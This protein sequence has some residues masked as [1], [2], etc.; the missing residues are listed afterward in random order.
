MQ[1]ILIGLVC[2]IAGCTSLSNS[3]PDIWWETAPMTGPTISTSTTESGD[4]S[5]ASWTGEIESNYKPIVYTLGTRSDNPQTMLEDYLRINMWLWSN[6]RIYASWSW[7][8]FSECFTTIPLNTANSVINDFYRK[9][10]EDTVSIFTVQKKT[11]KCFNFDDTFNNQW[12]SETW[13]QSGIF[14]VTENNIYQMSPDDTKSHR[15]KVAKK[16]PR[17]LYILKTKSNDPEKLIKEYLWY[18]YKIEK[19]W[20]ECFSIE[21]ED[22]FRDIENFHFMTDN[23]EMNVKAFTAW[24]IYNDGKWCG[25]LNNIAEGWSGKLGN[26]I[27]IWTTVYDRSR[28]DTMGRV[29]LAQ[30]E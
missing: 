30:K 25:E 19:T 17:P 27:V 5:D 12:I 3:H 18:Y 15:A 16:D 22:D 7:D 8:T 28:W 20:D 13:S 10:E 21:K 24:A 9:T 6:E 14:W 26:F 29:V 2:L 11:N 1:I 4:H 23:R